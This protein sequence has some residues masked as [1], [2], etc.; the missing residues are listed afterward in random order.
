[1]DKRRMLNLS[2]CAALLLTSLTGC[3]QGACATDV[4]EDDA[5]EPASGASDA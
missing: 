5:A 2:L 1:M 3:G 4:P